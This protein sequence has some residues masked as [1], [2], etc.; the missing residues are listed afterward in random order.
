MISGPRRSPYSF[1]M[2][3]MASLEGLGSAQGDVRPRCPAHAGDLPE[4]ARHLD[5]DPLVDSLDHLDR[6]HESEGVVPGPHHLHG[7]R[8][9]LP[10]E[11]LHVE[12][13]LLEEPLL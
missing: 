1:V 3:P 6:R 4:R 13:L 9:A 12:P 10:F 8:A 5:W 2:M 7:L 11:D